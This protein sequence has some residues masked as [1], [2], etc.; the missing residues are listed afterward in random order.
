[1]I[2]DRVRQSE[3]RSAPV[4]RSGADV[5][6]VLFTTLIST[7]IG[8]ILACASARGLCALEYPRPRRRTLL[9]ARLRRWYPGA[10]IV[11]DATRVHAPVKRWLARYFD[12]RFPDRGM[13]ALDLRGTAFELSVWEALLQIPVGK[14]DSYGALARRVA[15][16]NGA[17]AV[18]TAVGRN[19]ASIIVPC[20]R[21]VGADGS[22]TGY[23]GGIERKRWLLGHEGVTLDAHPER[24]AA[25]TAERP[26]LA[27]A[28]G[29]RS[30]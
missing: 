28:R 11:E 25:A 1:M 3:L 24:L 18:G 8:E 19:P 27:G 13:V 21:V 22:L 4:A 10:E 6:D 16:P 30:T 9:E 29:R 17:R 23:G 20:H 14:T 26:T 15:R 7:P 12:G 5:R 2:E